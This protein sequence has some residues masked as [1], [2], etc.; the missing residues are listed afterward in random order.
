MRNGGFCI[1]GTSAG[2][3]TSLWSPESASAAEFA[4]EKVFADL[5]IESTVQERFTAGLGLV[6]F[7]VPANYEP[8]R[9]SRSD[10]FLEH[11][12][13]GVELAGREH[14]RP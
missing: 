13:R 2:R 14:D 4:S 3:R 6:H 5:G 1:S 8:A 11:F 9:I 12:G 10:L 7:E